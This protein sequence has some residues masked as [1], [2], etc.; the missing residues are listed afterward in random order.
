MFYLLWLFISNG[1][2]CQCGAVKEVHA[3]VATEDSFGAAIVTQWD[4]MQH[5]SELPTDAF[6]VL[7]F[8]GHGRRH[9]HVSNTS[10]SYKHKQKDK[11]VLNLLNLRL[12]TTSL[13]LLLNEL[14]E[15]GWLFRRNS[16]TVVFLLN[17]LGCYR[18][19]AVNVKIH[20][21][22]QWGEIFIGKRL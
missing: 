18:S 2:L 10:S 16:L 21:K 3:S 7:E 13:L 8:A 12:A 17:C 15:C 20:I 9:S 11:S 6:G 22:G 4:S 1:A 14:A 5:S 19:Y